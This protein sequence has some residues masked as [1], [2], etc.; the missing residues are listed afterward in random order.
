[1][2]TDL[3]FGLKILGSGFDIKFSI[4]LGSRLAEY[5]VCEDI[6]LGGSFY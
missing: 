2:K 3:F 6:N 4:F 5:S 1:M